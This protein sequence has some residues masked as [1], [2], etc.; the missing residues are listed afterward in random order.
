MKYACSFFIL[1]FINTL[2][3]AQKLTQG[4]EFPITPGQ[5]NYGWLLD[6]NIND[7][8]YHLE[9]PFRIN[10][11][12]EHEEFGEPYGCRNSNEM[13]ESHQAVITIINTKTLAPEKKVKIS[14]IVAKQHN[15]KV[16]FIYVADLY[17]RNNQL[18]VLYTIGLQEPEHMFY[19]LVLDKKGEPVGKYHP[20][21]ALNIIKGGYVIINRY[22]KY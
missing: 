22:Q 11:G 19:C 20:L 6:G 18:V 2:L 8:I 14:E 13:A 12:Q 17:I 15:T 21:V 16:E 4:R 9:N 7:Y 10:V 5:Y 3:I 1:F